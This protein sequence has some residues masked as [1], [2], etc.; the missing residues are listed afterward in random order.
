MASLGIPTEHSTLGKTER[1]CVLGRAEYMLKNVKRSVTSHLLPLLLNRE[2][3]QIPPSLQNDFL[4]GSP[5][6]T[7]SPGF[8]I[9]ELTMQSNQMKLL[10]VSIETT[11][12]PGEKHSNMTT[13]CKVKTAAEDLFGEKK[14]GGMR[15]CKLSL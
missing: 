9:Q 5:S 15:F 10:V 3:E 14:C 2:I 12:N 4:K 13:E 7:F 6:L 11:K 8:Q 1:E